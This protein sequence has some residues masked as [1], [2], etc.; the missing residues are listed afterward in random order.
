MAKLMT[1]YA[2]NNFFLKKNQLLNN[3]DSIK[4]IP[5]LI[6]H[7]DIDVMC[8]LSGA[9]KLDALL[10]RG[11]LVVIPGG[12]HSYNEGRMRIPFFRACNSF[13]GKYFHF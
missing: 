13:D 9:R 4:D 6:L 2:S 1:Y 8:P 10:L 3:M 7:G 11:K 12:G 5:T